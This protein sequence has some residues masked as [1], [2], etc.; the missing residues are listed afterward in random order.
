L[1][2]EEAVKNLLDNAVL[3]GGPQLWRVSLA[4]FVTPGFVAITVQDDGLG[5]SKA[6]IP[7][8][9]ER[10]GQLSPSVGSGLGLSIAHAAATHHGGS[11][12][13]TPLNPGLCVELRL[14]LV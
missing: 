14:P 5:M 12:S 4:L 8:A 11:L 2:T 13:L 10:F 3:H 7:R 9:L 6:D 1:V